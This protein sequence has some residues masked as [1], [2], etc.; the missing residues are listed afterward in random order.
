MIRPIHLLWILLFCACQAEKPPFDLSIRL[1]GLK[2]DIT[3]ISEGSVQIRFGRETPF[4]ARPVDERG[5]AVFTQVPGKFLDD[6]IQLLYTPKD[7]R[8]F[9]IIDQNAATAEISRDIRFTLDFPGDHTTFEWSLR[10]QAGNGIQDAKVTVNDRISV[11]TGTNGYFAIAVPVPAGEKA[12]FKVE[13]DGKILIDRDEI[14]VPEYR[15][16]IV[17]K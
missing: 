5:I 9:R 3:P 15:R 13:K 12:H 14:V 1:N 8:R 11:M 4:P 17:D 6:S 16:L 10:D 7:G 2:G